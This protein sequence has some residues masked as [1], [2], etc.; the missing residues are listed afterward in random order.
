M[1]RRE[2]LE[3]PIL[4]ERSNGA[5]VKRNELREVLE[6]PT[7]EKQYGGHDTTFKFPVGH[8]NVNKDEF[9]EIQRHQ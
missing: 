2:V 4:K 3:L 9:S 1:T 5:K 7:L 8:D 6:L